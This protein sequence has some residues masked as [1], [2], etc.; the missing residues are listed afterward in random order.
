VLVL[1]VPPAAGC[2]DG[3][4]D[5]VGGT[6]GT[7][8][9]EGV[10]CDDGNEC[11]KDECNLADGSCNN[12]FVEDGSFCA[13]GYCQSGECEPIAS[14]FPCNEQGILDAIAAGAGPHGFDC[15]GPTL[16]TTTATIVIDNDVILDGRDNLTV[17]GNGSHPVF[18]VPMG[19]AAGLRRLAVSGGFC[20]D[21]G[22]QGWGAGISNEGTLDLVNCDVTENVADNC[23]AG[24]GL[25]NSG[26]LRIT[27]SVVSEN[28]GEFF[29]GIWNLGT[30]ELK[31][32]TVSGN[33]AIDTGLGVNGIFNDAEFSGVDIR[34]RGILDVARS[35]VS[36]NTGGKYGGL[37]NAGGFVSLTNSTI[38]NNSAEL[39]GAVFNGSG[40]E[41]G[42]LTITSTTVSGNTAMS[43]AGIVNVINAPSGSA[44]LT[45]TNSA[46][47]DT[48]AGFPQGAPDIS[49]GGYN[50]ESPG[51]TCRFDPDGTDL[52]DVTEQQLNLGPLADNGGPTMTHKPGDGGLAEGSVAIDRI[53]GD[54]CEV[55]TDQRGEPRP[56]AGGTMCDVGS[57]EVQAS[58]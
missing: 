26:T 18:S 47:D 36:E 57:V 42:A 23:L 33:V 14:V 13:A 22:F 25:G 48:C 19:V 24:A 56:E 16:V 38:S 37:C 4:K 20:T 29:G 35:T 15:K 44:L 45:M 34:P 5:G 3:G 53:P 10:E 9:C 6:G 52:V 30:M 11:T 21:P 17:D 2:S 28:A 54:A 1:G 40:P 31:D 7:D 51:D 41:Q 50:V 27:N 32:S 8:L 43:G 46:V 49:S 55:D 12:T 39:S 58:N